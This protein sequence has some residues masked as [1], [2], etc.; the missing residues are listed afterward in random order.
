M[1]LRAKEGEVKMRCTQNMG[2]GS[3]NPIDEEELS[4]LT[5]RE[6]GRSGMYDDTPLFEYLNASGEVIYQEFIQF[7]P[8]SSG[9]MECHA[10]KRISDGK[11]FSFW[12]QREVDQLF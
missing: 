10:F 9:P 1:V 4:Y 6:Y 12:M 11:L 8:W 7:S 2:Y 5:P 3:H